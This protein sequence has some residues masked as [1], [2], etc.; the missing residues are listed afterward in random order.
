MR[1]AKCILKENIFYRNQKI[2]QYF[3]K[4]AKCISVYRNICKELPIKMSKTILKSY[5]KKKKLIESKNY[6]CLSLYLSHKTV[7]ILNKQSQL[8]KRGN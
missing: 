1:N 5:L 8:E 7:Y 3:Q 2:A 6:N 4:I